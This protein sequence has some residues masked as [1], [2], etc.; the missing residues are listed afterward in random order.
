MKKRVLLGVVV[1]AIVGIV[2]LATNFRRWFS[3]APTE[4]SLTLYGNIDIRQV[5][6]A[7][8]NSERIEKLL[9]EEGD[10]VSPGQLLA[11]LK[12]ARFKW[13][14]AQTQA[15]VEAQKQIV[16]RLEAGSRPSEIERARADAQAIR[17]DLNDAQTRYRRMEVLVKQD[18]ET[19]Q[20]LDDA[21]ARLNRSQAQLKAAEATLQLLVEGPRVEDIAAARATLEVHKAEWALAQ[22]HLADANLYAP[23]DGTIRNRLLEPGD[24]ASPQK[25]V[26]TLALTNPLWARTY[27]DEP[28]LGKVR[29]GIAATITTDSFPD[30]HYD[31]WLGYISPI[32]EFTPKSVQT[33]ELR[34]QLVYEARVFVRD[35]NHELRL[36]MP[37]TVKIDLE[38]QAG[39]NPPADANVT[40]E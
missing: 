23:S 25:P 31:G 1:I 39:P 14:V 35:P 34:T 28:D 13:T 38:E 18:A 8:N 16:A 24:M 22:E 26:F 15:A 10:R 37:V 27:I 40:T 2:V 12:K 9:V 33:P 11:T 5:D 32:A 17:A 36:G 7:F 3:N 21:L 20:N 29:P 19:Q 6:L 4:N 30:K